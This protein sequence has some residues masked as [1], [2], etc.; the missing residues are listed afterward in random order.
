MIQPGSSL[1]AALQ[2][3]LGLRLQARRTPIDVVVIDA[4]EMPTAN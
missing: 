4:V 2:E 3:Q 1:T